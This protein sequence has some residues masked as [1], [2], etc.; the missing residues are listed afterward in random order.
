MRKRTWATLAVAASFGL[1]GVLATGGVVP[2][3]ANAS[4]ASGTGTATC[5]DGTI[6]YSPTTLWPPDHNMTTINISYA[7]TDNDGDSTMVSVMSITNNQ[8][9]GTVEDVGAG[10][11][12]LVDSSPGTPGS[13]SDS[14]ATG[15]TAKAATTTAQVRSERSGP[16]GSRIYTITVGCQDMGGTD[17]SD[18]S[19]AGTQ[20]GTA[21]LTVTVPH[22]QG[23]NV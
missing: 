6:T 12:N 7:D 16:D 1:A 3:V 20:M 8:T 18:M 17:P 23:N 10:N 22:D 11:P 13:G 5:N 19:E 14:S 4:H 21:T 9:T 2:A 15:G